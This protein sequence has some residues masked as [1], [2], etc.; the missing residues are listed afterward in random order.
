MNNFALLY[1]RHGLYNFYLHQIN[2]LQSGNSDVTLA[3]FFAPQVYQCNIM[4]SH[5]ILCTI[6][7]YT[8]GY[9]FTCFVCCSGS[10]YNLFRRSGLPEI[11]LEDC[12][13]GS[14]CGWHWK[15]LKTG[16]V[17][18]SLINSSLSTKVSVIQIPFCT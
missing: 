15:N 8:K 4:I 14:R 7:S 12:P 5:C 16:K 9:L 11:S 18:L 1:S 3:V 6:G 2:V 13:V 17:S 10:M